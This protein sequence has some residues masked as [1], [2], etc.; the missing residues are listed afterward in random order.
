MIWALSGNFKFVF[1]KIFQKMSSDIFNLFSDD[2]PENGGKFSEICSQ[3]PSHD[4][5]FNEKLKYNCQTY[6][7]GTN[8]ESFSKIC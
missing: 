2:F 5:H 4:C 3:E 8:D 7:F 6:V 1:W